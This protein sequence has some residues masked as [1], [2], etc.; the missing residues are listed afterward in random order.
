MAV[1]VCL[2]APMVLESCLLL[3][4]PKA[5]L[6]VETLHMFPFPKKELAL[7]ARELCYLFGELFSS[8]C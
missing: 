2:L 1:L 6:V 5:L 8:I 4:L 3:W 7:L